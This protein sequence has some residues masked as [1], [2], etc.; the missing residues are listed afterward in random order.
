MHLY[1]FILGRK[2]KI[3]IREIQSVFKNSKII[4]QNPS[5]LLLESEKEIDTK[6]KMQYL[7]GTIK[8]G[9]VLKQVRENEIIPEIAEFLIKKHSEKSK[10]KF[11]IQIV[12]FPI[13]ALSTFLIG[14]KKALRAKGKSGRFINKNFKNTALPAIISEGFLRGKGSEILLAKNEN[15]YLI[16]ETQAAQDIDKYSLRDYKKPFRDARMGMLPPKLA[17][18]LVNFAEL[19]K[20]QTLWDPFCGSGTVLME[21][22]MQNLK[23]I[24]SDIK[25]ENIDGTNQNLWWTCQEFELPQNYTTFVH[26]VTKPLQKK[27]EVDAIVCEGYLGKPKKILPPKKVL[28]K[29]IVFLEALYEKLFINLN[30][31]LNANSSVVICLPCFK[32]KGDYIF[33]ENIL[34]KI[35]ELGYSSVDL[36]KNRRKSLIYDRKDQ[37]VGREIF[38]FIKSV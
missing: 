3:S 11:G 22:L 27:I 8:L 6:L 16:A 13:R 12:N 21:G 4:E 28:D 24:G 10:I 15:G 37:I 9:K 23:V 20:G 38:K 35:K 14:T 1:L 30:S 26:D 29:E 32:N 36:N 34:E 33:L 5:Y 17:Q 18:I 25:K 7:G 31:V 2:S 19:E